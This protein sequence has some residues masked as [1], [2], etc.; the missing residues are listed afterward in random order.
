MGP[1]PLLPQ[2]PLHPRKFRDI[3]LHRAV[4]EGNSGLEIPRDG[5]S[6]NVEF[7][8]S[9]AALGAALGIPAIA[10]LHFLLQDPVVP[11]EEGRR[12][13]REPSLQSPLQNNHS[14]VSWK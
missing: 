10:N 12:V 4:E 6:G 5:V 3:V 13:W 2:R 9:L 8:S 7:N 1:E 11:E 14:F